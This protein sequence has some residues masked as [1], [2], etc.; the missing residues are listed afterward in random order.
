MKT[1]TRAL[2]LAALSHSLVACGPEA[3]DLASGTAAL[4]RE[5]R[6]GEG[7]RREAVLE[8][9]LTG[10]PRPYAGTGA[11]N[12]IRGV[13]AGGLPWVVGRGEAKLGR[14]GTLKVEVEGLVFDPDD[15]AVQERGLAGRNTVPELRAIVSCRTVVDGAA[16]VVNVTT[17]AFPATVG[18]SSDGGGDVEIEETLALASPCLAP[19]VFVTSPAGAWFAASG[20]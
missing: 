8:L 5:E 9:A 14:D 2:A 4:S 16:A 17:A 11:A 7:E 19:V 20:F 13:P 3:G 1:F 10:V 15:A 12:A 6:R 18:L